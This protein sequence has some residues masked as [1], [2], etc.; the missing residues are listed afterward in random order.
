MQDA[1]NEEIKLEFFQKAFA[2]VQHIC[3][4]QGS[5]TAPKLNAPL[6]GRFK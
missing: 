3:Y 6:N 4:K 2:N 1:N 5:V